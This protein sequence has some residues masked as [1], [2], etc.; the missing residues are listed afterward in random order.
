MY[1][2]GA[3]SRMLGIST[4]TL[5]TWEDRYGVVAPERSAGGQRLYSRLQVEH[6][7]YVKER[8]DSG[9]SPAD[10]HR[11]LTEALAQDP[12]AVAPAP[13]GDGP[14]VLILLAERDRF[15]AD[16]TRHLL[17]TEG[18]AVE[19]ALEA[20][21]AR[22]RAIEVR[23]QVAVVELLISGGEG[24]TLCRELKERL[25]VPVIAASTLDLRDETLEAGVD[26]FLLK[27]FN[28]LQLL[29]TVKDL[30]GRSALVKRRAPAANA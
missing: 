20:E 29:S 7:H 5:R 19:V 17:T 30:L 11:L 23:P 12:G 28:A 1:S 9:A 26:A 18:Y 22:E 16:F 3:V 13:P 24:T 15:A 14:G 21:A 8:I 25:D 6:L 27:P 2:I 10:A 4:R